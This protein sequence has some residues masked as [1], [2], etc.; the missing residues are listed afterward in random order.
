MI[1]AT[2]FRDRIQ[3]F[4]DRNAV[5][6]GI[7]FDSTDDNKAFKEKNGFPYDL[8]CDAD[9]AVSLVYGAAEVSSSRPSRISYLIDGNG[10]IKKVYESVTPADHPGEVLKDLS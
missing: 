3:E 10:Q 2:G 9:K 5:I 6:L 4:N 1:E 7:S 8:L